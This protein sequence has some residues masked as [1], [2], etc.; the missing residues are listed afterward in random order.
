[1]QSPLSINWSSVFQPSVGVL[2]VMIRGSIMYLALFAILRFIARRQSGRVGTADLLVI[3]LIADAA[4]NA[5][6]K[7]YQSVT[8][9]IVLVLT[10]VAWE[11]LLDWLAWRFPRLRSLLHAEPLKLVSG[12]QILEENMRREMLT[13]DELKAALRA[14]AIVDIRRVDGLYIEQSGHFSVI[15]RRKDAP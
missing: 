1:M 10:I 4:Q 7:E 6:G 12:G 9:G 2:E 8:E 14:K 11:Y 3:V 13:E 15:E 5:L